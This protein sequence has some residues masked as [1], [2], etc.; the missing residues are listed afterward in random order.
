MSLPGGTRL[1]PYEIVAPIGAGGMGEVYRARDGRLHR[2]V[3]VKVLPERFA[4]T[5][6]SRERFEREARTVSQ[7]AHQ[8]VCAIYDVGSENGVEYL[9]MELLEGET[10]ADRLGRGPLPLETAL[11]IGSQIAAALDAAHRK[12][13]VHRD[14]KPGNVMLTA[15]GVKLLDFG[16]ARG[17][18]GSG[19][20]SELTAAPT[21]ARD[22]TAEGSIIG[23]VPYMAPEQ[24]EGKRADART[25][26]F[27]L[28]S[29]LYE[30]VTGRKAFTGASQASLISAILTT[31]PPSPSA[32]QPMSPPA[33][34]RLVRT[35][36]AKD[37]ADRWQSAHDV[38]LQLRGIQEVLSSSSGSATAAPAVARSRRAFGGLPWAIALLATLVAAAAVFWKRP[39]PVSAPASMIR[40]AVP[41][42]PGHVFAGWGEGVSLQLSP[43]GR[44]LAFTAYRENGPVGIWV[45]DLSGEEARLVDGT[46]GANSFFWSPD[47]ESIAFFTSKRLARL[48]LTGGAPVTI[49]DL[50]GGIG[51]SG[52]WG[53]GGQILF[54]D[55]Q[56]DAIYSVPAD[57]GTPRAVVHSDPAHG[58]FRV[59]WPR[60][61]PDG[62][63][64][65][66]VAWQTGRKDNLMLSRPGRPPQTVIPLLSRA[67]F[68]EPGYL[69]YVREGVLFAQRFDV[70]SGKTAGPPLP[71][72]P[73]VNYFLSTGWADFT[74]R[75]GA[76]AYRSVEDTRRLEWVDRSGRV[77]DAVGDPGLYLDVAISPDGK[78]ALYSRARPGIWTFD[79]WTFDFARGVET[80]LTT[81]I[82]S[83]FGGVWLPDGKSIIYSTVAG[84]APQLTLRTLSTGEER[85]LAPNA[86]FQQATSVSA[87]G[88]VLAYNERAAGGSFNAWTLELGQPNARPSPFG[89]SSSDNAPSADSRTAH[90]STGAVPSTTVRFSPDGRVV[91]LLSAESGGLEA[92]VAPVGSPGEKVRVSRNGAF[93]PRFSRDGKELY[94]IGTDG[95]FMAVPIR[96]SPSVE[97]GEPRALFHIDPKAEW[98]AFDVSDD[99]RFLAI[100]QETSG[101]SQPASVV[102]NWAPSQAK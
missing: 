47:G 25:D 100:V 56:G 96:S 29:V 9:V 87:D 59:V 57:G 68:V 45:R 46:A 8:N 74:V 35:C 82:D 32:T 61:L 79:L 11:R 83:D 73:V 78:R 39:A 22:L 21:M 101:S 76:L 81:R 38:E 67:E 19:E 49:C 53:S 66:Y 30:M 55:V 80:P 93:Q 18:E 13:I 28:G 54:S 27:A 77:I 97:P 84:Q 43:D 12:G 85:R 65:L 94:Y 62:R 15:S 63:S 95:Q 69:V 34:D 24:L 48:P 86:A 88:R 99:G 98:T 3:A 58:N 33:L 44:R 64:F 16:L 71:L 72:A 70:D 31:E 14:L 6:E 91:A 23:T 36:L 89:W 60:F 40:F 7:L 20:S 52:T 10:L 92:Y 1:G 41:P 102:V 4:S 90:Y 5:P 17:F 51:R 2:D 75:R 50:G 42:P 37:P 26:L